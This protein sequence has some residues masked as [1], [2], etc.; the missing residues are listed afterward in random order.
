MINV[1]YELW[2]PWQTYLVDISVEVT[3]STESIM[4]AISILCM[5]CQEWQRLSRE[6]ESAFRKNHPCYFGPCIEVIYDVG[7]GLNWNTAEA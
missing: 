7:T 4:Q 3:T 1:M 6:A 5:D 2:Y